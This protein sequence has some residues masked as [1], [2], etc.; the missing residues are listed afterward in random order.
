[1]NILFWYILRHYLKILTMCLAGLTTIYLVVDFF[2]KLRKFL[3]Y[4]AELVTMVTYFFFKIPDISFK[5]VP[6]A[7]LMASLLAVGLLNKNHEITA[8]RSCGVS[9]IHVTMPFLAV[10]AFATAILFGFAAVVMPLANAKAEYIKTVKIQQ[11][12]QPLSFT[13]ENLWLHFQNDSIMH[14][15]RIDPDGTQ[16]HTV[17]LYRLDNHFHLAELLK[18]AR[19]EFHDGQ[20]SLRDVAQRSIQPKGRISTTQRPTLP[21]DLSLRPEDLQAWMSLEPEHMTL[22]QLMSHVKRLRQE[23]LSITR[24]LT[25]YWGR[26]AFAFGTLV[27]T[28]LGVSI[29]MR[30]MGTRHTS[31]AKGIGQAL[32][33][34]FLFWT[35]HSIGIALGRSCALLPVVAGWI[36]CFTFLIVGL[37]L[38]LRVRY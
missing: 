35:T 11:Q 14:V 16:L 25:D 30:R 32:A 38:F 26:V 18:A 1:M 37:N 19:A 2:E 36:A 6:F 8:M 12:P 24:F 13:A 4:D 28:I 9:I 21:L 34:S 20:W 15:R 33:V 3:R 31:I 27:M 23:G 29:G 22:G 7:S 10:A 5:L 17:T